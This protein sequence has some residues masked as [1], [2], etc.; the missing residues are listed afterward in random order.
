M[1]N[2]IASIWRPKKGLYVKDIGEGRY[3]FQF[4][5]IMDMKRIEDGSPWSFGTYLLLLHRLDKE[6]SSTASSP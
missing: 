2:R 3:V 6:G 1:K 5:H 4:F